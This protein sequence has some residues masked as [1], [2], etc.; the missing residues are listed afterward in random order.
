MKRKFKMPFCGFNEDM[1][2]GLRLFHRGL[3]EHGIIERSKKKG[4]SIETT[5]QNELND[6]QRFQKEIYRISNPK[7]RELTQNLTSYACS[8]YKLLQEKG[9]ENY[10]QL[11]KNLNN[12]YFEMDRKFYSELE[13]KMDDMKLLAE[14]LDKIEI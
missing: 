3:V 4:Q 10:S 9:I 11:I 7:I 13:G 2:K 8:F 1:L 12:F 6:M 14:Y 5:I